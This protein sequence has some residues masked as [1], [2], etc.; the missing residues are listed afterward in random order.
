MKRAMNRKSEYDEYFGSLDDSFV[1][2][3]WKD[4][5]YES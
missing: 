1:R 4:M 3:N 5:K 2:W